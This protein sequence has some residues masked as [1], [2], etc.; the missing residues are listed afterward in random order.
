MEE[1]RKI[2]LEELRDLAA[3]GIGEYSGNVERDIAEKRAEILRIK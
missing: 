1:L 2:A 3:A